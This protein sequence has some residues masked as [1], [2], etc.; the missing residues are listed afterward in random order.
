V[1]SQRPCCVLSTSSENVGLLVSMALVVYDRDGRLQSGFRY[2]L[3][4][5]QVGGV[6][7]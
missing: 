5:A 2:E 4:S 1:R 3:S 6:G 7:V